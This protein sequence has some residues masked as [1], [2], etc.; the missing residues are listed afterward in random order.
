MTVPTAKQLT[1]QCLESAA[2]CQKAFIKFYIATL[3]SLGE[4]LKNIC[5]LL[6]LLEQNRCS[7]NE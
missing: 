7:A 4:T 1:L 2:A 3:E 6:E 5:R